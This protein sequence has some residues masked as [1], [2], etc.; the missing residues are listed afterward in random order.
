MSKRS[1]VAALAG[2]RASQYCA[3]RRMRD[4]LTPSRVS[5][6][7]AALLRALTSTKTVVPKRSAMRSIS[8]TGVL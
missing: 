1:D 3:A 6:S 2:C 7:L 8:P 5:A 4:W